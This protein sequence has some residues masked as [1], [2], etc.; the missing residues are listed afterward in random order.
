MATSAAKP[1]P[2][3]ILISNMSRK[4]NFIIILHSILHVLQKWHKM[5]SQQFFMRSNNSSTNPSSADVQWGPVRGPRTGPTHITFVINSQMMIITI[6]IAIT[7]LTFWNRHISLVFAS[8]PNTSI[9]FVPTLFFGTA[10]GYM[11]MASNGEYWNR[12]ATNRNSSKQAKTAPKY[13]GLD[14]IEQI[15]LHRIVLQG[16]NMFRVEDSQ[17]L[18]F[19]NGYWLVSDTFNIHFNCFFFSY[20]SNFIFRYLVSLASNVHPHTRE[21][22]MSSR[23][24]YGQT[25][26]MANGKRRV[27]G[28]QCDDHQVEKRKEQQNIYIKI[29]ERKLKQNRNGKTW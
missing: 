12:A 1:L 10:E 26:L 21:Y 11:T 15:M 14:I 3:P 22:V 9:S 18:I 5:E 19:L 25:E 2:P 23:N 17:T 16:V 8:M 4:F 7:I 24:G 28:T 20:F 27:R 29:I 6:I 13:Y